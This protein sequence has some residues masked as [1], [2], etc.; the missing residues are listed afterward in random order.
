MR[1][2]LHVSAS[3]IGHLRLTIPP[4]AIE[5]RV[6]SDG[7]RVVRIIGIDRGLGYRR[8]E[9]A[10]EAVGAGQ[11]TGAIQTEKKARIIPIGTRR[12]D[13]NFHAGLEFT[14]RTLGATLDEADKSQLF[15]AKVLGRT[16]D[17]VDRE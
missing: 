9:K 6:V 17:R 13:H 11:G 8:R 7:I 15:D 5:D 10:M 1:I 12:S 2:A 3:V 16:V 4:V 14:N